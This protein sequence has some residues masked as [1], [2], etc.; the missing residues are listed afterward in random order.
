MRE[1]SGV[2]SFVWA[3]DS[4]DVAA[5]LRARFRV[6]GVGVPGGPGVPPMAG[7]GILDAPPPHMNLASLKSVRNRIASLI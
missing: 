6:D 5:L 7:V 4:V 2:R 3:S 1:E